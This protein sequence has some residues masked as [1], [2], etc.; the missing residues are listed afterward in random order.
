MSDQPGPQTE[1]NPEDLNPP[2]PPGWVEQDP[3]TPPP[4][5]N[6]VPDI[7]GMVGGW[8]GAELA[9]DPPAEE[10]PPAS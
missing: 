5:R 8:V 1:L 7:G 6:G 3:H 4:M 2:P 9:N 10:A